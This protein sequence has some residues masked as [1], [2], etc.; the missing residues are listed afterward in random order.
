MGFSVGT[1]LEM[2]C[3]EKKNSFG[4]EVVDL[5]NVSNHANK[6]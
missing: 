3:G 5:T 4:V 1:R 2:L 6:N